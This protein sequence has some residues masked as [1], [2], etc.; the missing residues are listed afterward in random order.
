MVETNGIRVTK[1]Q[2]RRAKSR[3]ERGEASLETL[4]ANLGIYGRKGSFLRR[5]WAADLGETNVRG[6]VR[7][8]RKVSA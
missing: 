1:A 8:G 4:E 2:L 6:T 3:Y 5:A 7:G